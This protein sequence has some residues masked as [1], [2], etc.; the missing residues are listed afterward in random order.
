MQ[1][2]P[3]HSWN[4]TDERYEDEGSLAGPVDE[5][6]A[7]ECAHQ[8]DQAEQHGGHVL[9]HGRAQLSE[10]VHLKRVREI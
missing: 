9:V 10:D 1:S 7:D 5:D 3:S 2:I 4:L 6:D 8:L